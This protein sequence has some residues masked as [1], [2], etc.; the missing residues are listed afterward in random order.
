MVFEMVTVLGSSLPQES[1]VEVS[2]FGFWTLICHTTLE[3]DQSGQSGRF[4]IALSR[5]MFG[6]I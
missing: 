5:P 3:P 4:N 1:D 6:S 2:I